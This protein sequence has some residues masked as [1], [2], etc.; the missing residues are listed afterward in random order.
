MAATLAIRDEIPGGGI[1]DEW[2]LEFL[3]DVIT[4]RELIRERVYQEAS[5]YDNRQ[6]GIGIYR[7]LVPP[8]GLKAPTPSARSQLIDWNEQYE[9]A[10]EAFESNQVLI[11]IDDHQAESLD[12][13]FKIGPGTLVTFVRL[14]L[15]MGG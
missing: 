2:S 3:S 10:V 6:H 15:L 12:Q 14:N 13:S 7:G 11:L 9:K 1:S 8:K 4:V 5:D